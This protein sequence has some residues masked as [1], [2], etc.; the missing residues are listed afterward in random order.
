MR[1]NLTDKQIIELLGGA[2]KVAKLCEISVPAVSQWQN[3]GIPHTQMV[4]LGAELEKQSHGLI[5]R[6]D[7]FPRSWHLIW[8]E[9]L[10]KLQD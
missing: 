7:L 8:P 3:N 2:T 10:P 9:L 4:F 1:L 6:K 5:T